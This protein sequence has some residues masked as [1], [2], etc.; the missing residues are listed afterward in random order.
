[1]SLNSFDTWILDGL[2]AFKASPINDP[3]EEKKRK[4]HG[5]RSERLFQHGDFPLGLEQLDAQDVVS[6]CIVL[7]KQP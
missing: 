3:L 6:R 1:M 4:S 2:Q 7:V 5:T